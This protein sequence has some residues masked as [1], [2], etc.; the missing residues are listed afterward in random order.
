MHIPEYGY[1]HDFSAN[2]DLSAMIIAITLEELKGFYTNKLLN[3]PNNQNIKLSIKI[4]KLKLI[5]IFTFN[6]NNYLDLGTFL[7]KYG[8]DLF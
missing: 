4:L 2:I 5:S 6:I 7:M 1:K 3:I 8:I